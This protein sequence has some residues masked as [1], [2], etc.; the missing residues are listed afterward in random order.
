LS[1]PVGLAFNSTGDL[2]VGSVGNGNIYEITPTGEQSIFASGLGSL[3]VPAGLAFNNAGD[4]FVAPRGSSIY[5]FTPG[6]IK[7][8][9][10]SGLNGPAYLVFQ[11][12]GLPVPEPSVL[13]LLAVGFSA[14]LIHC[15]KRTTASEIISEDS[16]PVV[17]GR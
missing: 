17:D 7:S 14:L 12:E 9:F 8:A 13:G 2:F 10:A 16:S 4:L 11:G 1:T 3:L 15:R 6:G 5:E